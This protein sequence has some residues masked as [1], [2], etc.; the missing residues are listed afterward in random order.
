MKKQFITLLAI[1]IGLSTYAQKDEIKAAEKALKSGDVATAKS[2][3]DQAEG[4]IAN[5]DD[6]IKANFYFVKAKTYYDVAKKNPSLDPNAYD[7][8]AKSFQKL[9]SFEKEI[10]KNKYT[11][12]AQPLLSA[13]VGDVSQ[14][15]IKEYQDKNYTAAT[16][17]L[18]QTYDLSQK[19]TLF[20][21]YA[22]N[23]AY[24]DENYD[25]ALDY[26][27]RLK[28][29]GYTGITTEYSAT[30]IETGE[31]ENFASKSQMDIMVKSNQYKDPKS[32]IS[33]SKRATVVKNIA[34]ILVEK[35]EVENAITAV[36]EARKIA[37]GDINILL[38]EA[39]L[40]LKL[41]KKEEFAALMK[42]AIK[43]DP[44]NPNL[45]FN[46]GVINQEQGNVEEAKNYYNKAI[47]LDPN[48]ADAYINLGALTLEKDKEYVEEMNKN[49][50]NFSKYDA[51]KAKQKELYKEVLPFYEK[52]YT[53]KKKDIEIVRTLMSL[54]ENLEMDDKF[55]EMK[56]LWDARDK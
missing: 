9:I 12:E 54:Y 11:E 33:E 4:L 43:Q 48:Y 19:D 24:L 1:F 18:Y 25:T 42:E 53:I 38:T 7:T 27:K 41:G 49:L 6:K 22:A 26:F 2:S 14:K 55:K 52:A 51:I 37:P 39:N 23:A 29:M 44:N 32:E 21:E 3:V 50:S 20:L 45:H 56:A 5:A 13:L 35:G 16:K 8:A 28:D 46:V 10:G 15:G 36:Q 34:Y 40:L 17:S 31:V 30:N 47:E